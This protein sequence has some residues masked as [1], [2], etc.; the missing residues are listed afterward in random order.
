[1][2]KTPLLQII[3]FA[4]NENCIFSTLELNGIEICKAFQN[5]H[6]PIP[7]G[8]YSAVK[9]FSPH[10]KRNVALLTVPDHKYVEIHPAN[11]FNQLRGCIAPVSYLGITGG[12]DS[13]ACVDRI[14]ELFENSKTIDIELIER[15]TDISL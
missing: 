6:Y 13:N 14:I 4:K 12:I 9:Y 8:K 5:R 15:W 7:D 10:L 2:T 3:N 1:M 11:H